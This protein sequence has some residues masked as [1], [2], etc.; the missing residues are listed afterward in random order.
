M[1]VRNKMP[2]I[3]AEHLGLFIDKLKKDGV[4]ILKTKMAARN[5][6]PMQALNPSKVAAMKDNPRS[7][8]KP[9]IIAKDH[10]IVDGHHRYGVG[11]ETGKDLN[12]LKINLSF[13]QIFQL[14]HEFE[15]SFTKEFHEEKEKEEK[16]K[17]EKEDEIELSGKREKIITDPTLNDIVRDVN[18]EI[19][20]PE[21]EL[22][23][24]DKLPVPEDST[25]AERIFRQMYMR[26]K[27]DRN[28]E[29]RAGWLKLAKSYLTKAVNMHFEETSPDK[30]DEEKDGEKKPS[31]K[32]E[33]FRP[34]WKNYK[35]I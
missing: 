27:G 16:S 32:S 11:L 15:H 4:A 30:E 1:I 25:D 18:E 13:D 20:K 17:E 35:Y 23:P 3:S 29:R 10:K 21:L 12:I 6:I 33:S 14:M 7:L 24:K 26:A 19:K 31:D 8:D 34:T 5:L 28:P 22:I 2:Q 9:V